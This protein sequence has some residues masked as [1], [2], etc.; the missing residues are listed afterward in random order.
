M[1][2]VIEILEL[3]SKEN[4]LLIGDLNA[5]HPIW[6]RTKVDNRGRHHLENLDLEAYKMEPNHINFTTK[7]KDVL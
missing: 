7:K 4:T 1:T 6:G 2:S 3:I 5:K